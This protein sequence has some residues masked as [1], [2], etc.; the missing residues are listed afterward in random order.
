MKPLFEYLV[1]KEKTTEKNNF[2]SN[3]YLALIYDYVNNANL[4]SKMLVNYEEALDKMFELSKGNIYI[5][6]LFNLFGYILDTGQYKISRLSGTGPTDLKTIFFTYDKAMKYIVVLI[7]NIKE[8][9]QIKVFL[10]QDEFGAKL[11]TRSNHQD[12]YA[13][14]WRTSSGY[15]YD[16]PFTSYNAE[17]IERISELIRKE[18]FNH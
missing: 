13:Y 5:N 7:K 18:L 16:P 4:D 11:L 9:K 3:K 14:Y 1:S 17:K 8:D 12:Y 10:K 15:N 2:E 6:D